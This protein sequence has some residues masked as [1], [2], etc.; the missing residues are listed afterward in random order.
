MAGEIPDSGKGPSGT[1]AV[2]AAAGGSS[3]ASA[4]SA[5]IT[6]VPA[7]IARVSS[8]GSLAE[9]EAHLVMGLVMDGEATPAQISALVVGM[10]MKGETV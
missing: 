2:I 8:G 5:E 9:E 4:A 1:P 6:G 3:R 7:A 10:R